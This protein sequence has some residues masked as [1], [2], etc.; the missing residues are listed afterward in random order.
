M[1]EKV[2]PGGIIVHVDVWPIIESSTLE[3]AIFKREPQRSNEVERGVR[4]GTQARR[5]A[6]VGGNFGFDEDDVHTVA[7]SSQFSVVSREN[8]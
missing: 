6:S 5:C 8:G 7:V 2:T 3:V 4:R 1:R